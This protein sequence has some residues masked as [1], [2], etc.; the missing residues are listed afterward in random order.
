MNAPDAHCPSA[1]F[2]PPYTASYTTA[3]ISQAEAVFCLPPVDLDDASAPNFTSQWTGM[4]LPED[5]GHNVAAQH[6]GVASPLRGNRDPFMGNVGPYVAT[7][8]FPATP[9]LNVGDHWSTS[10]PSGAPDV[11]DFGTPGSASYAPHL[12]YPVQSSYDAPMTSDP[13]QLTM[14]PN[15]PLLL[16]CSLPA[17][18]GLAYFDFE[19]ASQFG[20]QG[21]LAELSL[22]NAHI[23]YLT[24]PPSPFPPTVGLTY[25]AAPDGVYNIPVTSPMLP[26]IPSSLQSAP[27]TPE[28]STGSDAWVTDAEPASPSPPPPKAKRASGKRK[29][30]ATVLRSAVERAI[31]KTPSKAKSPRQPN[32]GNPR[33]SSPPPP[34]SRY[35]GR[36]ERVVISRWTSRTGAAEGITLPAPVKVDNVYVCP[37]SDCSTQS[38]RRGDVKR[39]IKTHFSDLRNGPVCMGVRIADNDPRTRLCPQRCSEDDAGQVW[40]GGC[41]REFSR[42]ETLKRHVSAKPKCRLGLPPV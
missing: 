9:I 4:P 5:I 40:F 17:E 30:S 38:P 21:K 37:V 18:A 12:P 20:S 29:T 16:P 24:P 22:G 23:P 27:S 31:S 36:F 32:A 28:T 2:A 33:P 35:T 11:P 6:S 13:L 1:L 10:M 41:W 14:A 7:N 8:S 19:P 3:L 42:N 15:A 34:S 39:H 25:F 26:S